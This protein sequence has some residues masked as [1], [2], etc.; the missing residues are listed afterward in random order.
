MRVKFESREYRWLAV[1]Q[2]PSKN[3]PMVRKIETGCEFDVESEQDGWMHVTRNPQGYVMAEYVTPVEDDAL[4]SMTINEL[5][6]LAKDSGV[7]L[8]SGMTKAQI[9]EALLNG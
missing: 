5:R 6:K 3:A 7:T 2:R 8:K 4:S 1:R 9:I